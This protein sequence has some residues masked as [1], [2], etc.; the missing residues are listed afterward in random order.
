MFYITIKH[1]TNIPKDQFSPKYYNHAVQIVEIR[2]GIQL[3]TSLYLQVTPHMFE[4]RGSVKKKRKEREKKE[5]KRIKGKRKKQKRNKRRRDLSH[6]IGRHSAD[7]V[8]KKAKI[9]AVA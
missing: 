7:G 9:D 4:M 3:L 1:Q 6:I 2:V 5:K 8:S